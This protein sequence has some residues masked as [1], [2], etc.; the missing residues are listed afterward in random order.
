MLCVQYFHNNLQ[1]QSCTPLIKTG[2]FYPIFWVDAIHVK[3]ICLLAGPTIRRQI[4]GN[5]P[6]L[7]SF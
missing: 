7:E 6:R 3:K 2:V 5:L 4:S 1:A